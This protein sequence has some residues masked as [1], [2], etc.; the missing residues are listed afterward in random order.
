MPVVKLQHLLGEPR[1]NV[2]A[3]G[4][5]ADRNFFLDAPR[6]E[7]GPHP[8]RNVPVQLAHRVGPPRHLEADDGHRERLLI[9]LR[10]DAPQAHELLV[11]DAEL[12]AQRAQMLFDQAA[13]KAVVTGGHRRV[14]G[15]D[16]LAGDFA[17]GVVEPHAVVVHPLANHFQRAERAV[18]FVEVIDAGRDAQGPQRLH[19]A[20]A[21]HQLLAN[22]GPLV[23]AIQPA[24]Q[25]AVL[26]AVAFDVAVEQEQPHA[27]DLHHP[28]LGEQRRRCAYR[29]GR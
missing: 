8:P 24:R 17:Q 19:A 29:R 14:R 15:E 20:D 23:A 10:L 2:H 11:A 9:V 25:L 12:I 6:P 27:A 13:V 4:D 21:Q 26:R 7:R 3:V 28:H 16:G 22:A 1:R 5:V 18:P